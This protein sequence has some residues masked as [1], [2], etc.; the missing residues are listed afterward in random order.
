[1]EWGLTRSSKKKQ[2]SVYRPLTKKNWWWQ[3]FETE[4]VFLVEFMKQGTSSI[5]TFIVKL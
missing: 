3:F 5:L 1:M 4:K 2:G